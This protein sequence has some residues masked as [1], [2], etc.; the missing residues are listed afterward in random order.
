MEY[1]QDVF[2]EHA[3]KRAF[4]VAA[5]GYD[6]VAVLQQEINNRLLE[7]FD[8]FS[9]KCERLLDL[10]SGTGYATKKLEKR[11]KHTQII[12][13]DLSHS[14][15]Y[16]SKIKQR[17]FFSR[18]QHVCNNA[19][20]LPFKNDSFDVVYC[21]LMLQWCPNL[22]DVFFEINRVLRQGG[23]FVFSSF[24]PDTLKELRQSWQAVDSEVHVNTFI[25][26]H[27]VGDALM[28][29]VLGEPV[30]STEHMQIKY[31]EIKQLM[32][33]LKQIGAQN[34][35]KGRRKTL[36]GKGRIEKLIN[37]YES[38]RDNGVLPATYEV[39]YGH[40]WKTGSAL[41]TENLQSVSLEE[42]RKKLKEHRGG[43]N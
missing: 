23:V 38:F 7:C 4:N 27:D 19:K 42:M 43:K 33:E 13:A 24:G 34:N 5:N 35:N 21:N 6:K 26:M 11:F 20:Q 10:G 22:D 41:N 28:R 16:E 32:N 14:M 18:Q 9:I 15:L 2:D 8:L 3:I 31:E 17:R 25:D 37:H 12:Q 40:A 36:T 39:I 1:K 29:N 30:L